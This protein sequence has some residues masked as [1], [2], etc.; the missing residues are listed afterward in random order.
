MNTSPNGTVLTEYMLNISRLHTPKR[1]RK[2]PSLLGKM[3]R[4]KEKKKSIQK[5]D[6]HHLWEAEGEKFLNSEKPPHGGETSWDRKKTLEDQRGTQQWSVEGRTKQELPARFVPQHSLS[7][8]SPAAA[9][10]KGA[11]EAA[12]VLGAGKQ[13]SER[14]SREYSCLL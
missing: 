13:G 12:V 11:G 1:T 5:R 6:Q 3:K 10:E 9:E 2:I 7:H 8:L 4:K 14:R